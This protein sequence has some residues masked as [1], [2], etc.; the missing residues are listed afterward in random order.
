MLADVVID[1]NVLM[2]ASDPRQ[3]HQEACLEVIARMGR[4]ST[5]LCVDEGTNPNRPLEGFMSRK[6]SRSLAKQLERIRNK[7]DR[8]FVA[9]ALNSDE[10]VLASQDFLDFPIATRTRIWREMAV[11]I[12]DAQEC[13]T[14]L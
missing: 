5:L 6:V 12:I 13:S 9:V 14:R 11:A 3:D 8:K 4:C 7:R 2:H 10:N 1:T